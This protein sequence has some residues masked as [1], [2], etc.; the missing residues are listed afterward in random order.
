MSSDKLPRYRAFM[1]TAT[2]AHATIESLEELAQKL[3]CEYS[4]ILHDQDKGT[5]HFH[6]AINLKNA[7]TINAIAKNLKMKPNFIQKWD[8]RIYNM[9]AYMIHDTTDAKNL[10]ADYT[11]YMNNADKFRTNI[12]NYLSRTLAPDAGGGAKRNARLEQ[13]IDELLAGETTR[14]ELLKPENIR[15]YFDNKRKIETAIQLRTESLRFN[16]PQCKTLYIYGPSGTGKTTNAYKI[17]QDIYGESVATASSS[18]DL[19]QDYTG[20]KCLIIDDF[21]PHDVPFSELLALLDPIHRQRTHRSRYFNKPLATD[22]IVITSILSFDEVLRFYSDMTT[23]EDMKQLRR[24]VQQLIE[25]KDGNQIIYDYNEQ[26]D[27]YE[28]PITR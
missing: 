17:A 5:D 21:R 8:K 24:R 13:T 15:F 28:Y 2:I 23:N 3:D 22:L 18:N 26:L 9:W 10:K 19:L 12:D 4:V 6:L 14:K 27:G 1:A 20:E 25:F 7:K 11:E 16:P